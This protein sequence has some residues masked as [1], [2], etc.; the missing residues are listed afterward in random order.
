MIKF[1]NYECA[2][3]TLDS[4][5]IEKSG[6]L[7]VGHDKCTYE[8]IQQIPIILVNTFS[9]DTVLINLCMSIFIKNIFSMKSIEENLNCV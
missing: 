4:T 2:F 7:Y 5:K 8:Y 6:G 3:D 1:H 9:R